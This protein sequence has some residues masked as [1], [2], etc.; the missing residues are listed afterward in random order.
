M[1]VYAFGCNAKRKTKSFNL[2]RQ[3]CSLQQQYQQNKTF[4][5]KTRYEKKLPAEHPLE[6]SVTHV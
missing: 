3:L 4:K 5:I 6:L 1:P 2:F